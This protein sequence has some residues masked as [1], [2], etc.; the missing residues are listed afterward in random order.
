MFM[1]LVLEHTIQSV[2][3]RCPFTVEVAGFNGRTGRPMIRAKLHSHRTR[4]ARPR[5]L[6]EGATLEVRSSTGAMAMGALGGW[7]GAQQAGRTSNG[8]QL[9]RR[10]RRPLADEP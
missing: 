10:R 7:T 4:E 5:A 6:G 9:R 8:R 1:W 3:P 2:V